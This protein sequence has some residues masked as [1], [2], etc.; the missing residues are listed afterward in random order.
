VD[1]DA[2]EEMRR[3]STDNRTIWIW[4][5]GTNGYITKESEKSR[6]GRC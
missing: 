4:R 1:V 6:C 5:K 2:V 3:W